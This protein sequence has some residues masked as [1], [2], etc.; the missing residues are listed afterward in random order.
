MASSP[1]ATVPG[2]F[3]GLRPVSQATCQG[4]AQGTVMLLQGT[5]YH[6]EDGLRPILS[7]TLNQSCWTVHLHHT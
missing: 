6:L 1:L 2:N 7:R 4:L 3:M 5:A